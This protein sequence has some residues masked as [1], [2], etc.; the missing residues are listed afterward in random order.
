MSNS[1][2]RERG[3]RIAEQWG[4]GPRSEPTITEKASPEFWDMTLEHVW[5]DVWGRPGLGLRER[6]MITIA[7]IISLGNPGGGLKAH[8]RNAANVGV[9]REEILEII[10]HVAH[11]AG[12]P[13]ATDA[14]NQYYEVF[15]PK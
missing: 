15:K 9:K 14:L 6:E 11:Y 4:G 12:W 5:C 3:R 2:R 10:M 13:A 8:L 7:S 1:E